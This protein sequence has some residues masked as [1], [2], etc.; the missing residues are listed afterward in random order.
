MKIRDMLVEGPVD[1]I[2]KSAS[3]FWH[4]TSGE[5]SRERRWPMAYEK[6]MVAYKN[7]LNTGD[8]AAIDKY[9]DLANYFA[10]LTGNPTLSSFQ[11]RLLRQK[12]TKQDF[13]DHVKQHYADDIAQANKGQMEETTDDAVALKKNTSAANP[14]DKVTLDIP[15]LIRLLEY[16]RED[17]E[18]DMDLHDLT[19]KLIA[20]GSEGGKT[21]S[22][23]DYDQLVQNS[24][25]NSETPMEEPIS[26]A[27]K[28]KAVWDKPNPKKK[29][30]KLTPSQK[31]KAK[32]RAKKA[33][34]A[35]P[36]MVDNIWAAK[37][38]EQVESK[39]RVIIRLDSDNPM[40]DSM[41]ATLGGAGS[42]SFKGLRNKARREAEELA[43]RLKSSDHPLSFRDSAYNVNQLANTLNTI[44]AAYD[45]LN[46]IRKQGGTRS[47]GIT[48][49]E[50]Q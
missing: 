42:W 41:V 39:Q 43:N 44:V 13:V 4:G 16:A 28:A 35:Y 11:N 40:D 36:N 5:I 14:K 6:S 38:E 2:K 19:E 47:R 22:M 29:H 37:L 49:S 21:L 31:S 1:S 20:L 3:K 33:G 8:F 26:E 45:E 9:S 25:D 27:K 15:L 34:R 32:A 10:L 23:S 17:A 48:A 18:S 12:W 46:G 24:E 50:G 7:A 30:K